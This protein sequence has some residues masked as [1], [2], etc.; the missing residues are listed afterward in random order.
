MGEPIF[1]FD[2]PFFEDR[3]LTQRE[4][5]SLWLAAHGFTDPQIGKKLGIS[6]QTVKNY[7][8]NA[9]IKLGATNTA[10]AVFL[11]YCRPEVTTV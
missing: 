11:R 8:Q 4:V 5:E 9:R 10:H 2:K 1:H 6:G 3:P 7:L